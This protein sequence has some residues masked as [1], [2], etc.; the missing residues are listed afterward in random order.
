MNKKTSDNQITIL[1]QNL[2]QT[3]NELTS[4]TKEIEQL[5]LQKKHGNSICYFKQRKR[6]FI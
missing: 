1:K 5:E 3:N 2:H 4:K 6:Y